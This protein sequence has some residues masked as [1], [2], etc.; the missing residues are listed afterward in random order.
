MK[1]KVIIHPAAEGGYWAED[2]AM[3]GCITE[4]ETREEVIANLKDAI[5]GWIEV[6][7]SRYVAKITVFKNLVS[8]QS[9]ELSN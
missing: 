6:A 9:L 1:I 5:K 2:P 7:S 3:S 8:P 4:G